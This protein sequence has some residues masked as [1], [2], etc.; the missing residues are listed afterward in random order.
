MTPM[1]RPRLVPARPR[2]RREVEAYLEELQE[3]KE[4]LIGEIAEADSSAEEAIAEW[5]GSV[6]QYNAR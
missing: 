5:N 2:K 3:Y 4:C 6:R 1:A